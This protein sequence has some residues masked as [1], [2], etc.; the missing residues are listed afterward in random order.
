[1]GEAPH[2][3]PIRRDATGSV[4]RNTYMSD[5]AFVGSFP[6]KFQGSTR[7]ARLIPGQ[8]TNP[9]NRPKSLY[10]VVDQQQ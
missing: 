3:A 7:E 6:G 10:A 2:A 1:M 5:S 9:H 4:I 8:H